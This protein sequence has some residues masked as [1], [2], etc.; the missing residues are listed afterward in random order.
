MHSRHR[1][2]WVGIYSAQ[3]RYR[4]HPS[5]KNFYVLAPVYLSSLLPVHL[6][7]NLNYMQFSNR[8]GTLFLFMHPNKCLSI[9]CVLSSWDRM[10]Q[11]KILGVEWRC[12][13]SGGGGTET[14]NQIN[15]KISTLNGY[16]EENMLESGL[17]TLGTREVLFKKGTF[18]LKSEGHQL[19]LSTSW[20]KIRSLYFILNIGE[21]TGEF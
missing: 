20:T 9:Y 7:A 18:N 15:K 14:N 3:P 4:W 13:H 8:S 21:D 12:L 17:F 11:M 6:P 16:R 10:W 5:C 2:W 19:T 1:V